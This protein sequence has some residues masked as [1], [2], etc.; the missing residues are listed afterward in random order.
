M[1]V[2]KYKGTYAKWKLS[3]KSKKITQRLSFGYCQ[4]GFRVILG[5]KCENQSGF[6]LSA[7][8]FRSDVGGSR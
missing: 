8:G 3:S 6:R 1:Q 2:A 7:P 5:K 4:G